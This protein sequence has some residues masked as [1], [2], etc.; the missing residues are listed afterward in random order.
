MPASGTFLR[1]LPF[2]RVWPSLAG[3]RAA[4]VPVR[5]KWR[6]R[7]PSRWVGI[8]GLIG[9]GLVVLET[10]TSWLQ[11]ELLAATAR[12]L[13]YTVEA[14]P[15]AS[16]RF[17]PDGPY[18]HRLGY[19]LQPEFMPRLLQGGFVVQEQAR[20]SPTALTL[21][22]RGVFHIH[23]EKSQAGLV[24]LDRAG[25]PLADAR[26]PR[27]V[28]QRFD[29]IPPLIV[30]TIL[31]IENRSLLR[32]GHP[33]R[34]PAVEYPRLVHAG[35]E[36]GLQLVF[37]R[38]PAS[39][40]S[41]LATQLEKIR[42]S[43]GGRTRSFAD[44]GT[45]MLSAS[46]RAYLDGVETT[47]ARER[48]VLDYLNSLPLGA[49]AGHGEVFGLG[50]GLWAWYDADFDEVNASLASGGLVPATFP[51]VSDLA[52]AYRQVLSLLLAIKKP[53][54]YLVS[55][56]AS[57]DARIDGY[58][59]A[60][61]QAEVISPALR[62]EA[63]GVRVAPRRQVPLP[64]VPFAERKATDRVRTEL[65]STLGLSS[66]YD[67]DRLD[68]TVHSTLD[69]EATSAVTAS[70]QQLSD[71]SYA[72]N[73]GV[74]AERLLGTGD[75][76]KVLYSF[77]LYERG[78]TGH[79]L[80]VQADNYDGPLNLNEGTRLELGSTAKLRTLVS[81]LQVIEALHGRYAGLPAEALN[82]VRPH[83]RD[84]LTRWAV[85][86][87]SRTTS[88]GLD[89]MLE[90][91]MVRRYSASP[92]ETFFTGGGLHRFG[93][94]DGK[95]DGRVLT[96]REAFER[97]VNLV[98]VRLMRDVVDHHV[99]RSPELGR[100]LEDRTHPARRGYLE[101]FADQE[102]REFLRRFHARNVNASS[103]DLLKRFAAAGRASSTRLAMIFRSVRPDAGPEDLSAFLEFHGL[104]DLSQDRV[105]DL[106]E[107]YDPARWNLQDRGYIAGVHPLELWL[108]GYLDQ[109]PAAGLAEV[110]DAS[111]AARQEAYLWLFR[112][113]NTRAQD[114]SIR[115]LLEQDAFSA[116]HAS[117]QRLGYPFASL[118]PSYAT[119]LG[120]SGDNPAALAD[121]VGT[122]LNGGV[123]QPA[124][125]IDELLFGEGTP[126]HTRL[127]RPASAGERVLSPE[128]AGVLREALVGV[129]D[130]GTGRRLAGGV[131]LDGGHR[132]VVG[133]KTGTGDNRFETVGPSGRTQRV[134]NR[135]AAFVFT[136]GERHFGTIVAFVPGSD[137]ARY[138]FTSALPVQIF[139]HLVPALAPLLE[140]EEAR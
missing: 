90:A 9:T 82:A 76:H 79:R 110:M 75:L 41:T 94:F 68:L 69:G 4:S 114:R 46:L 54:A 56:P 108:A 99:F 97:S 87:L 24:V 48:L 139:R 121:L 21:A 129:V 71:R 119:A 126:Y 101:R 103:A 49:I 78:P 116:I 3:R 63:R 138:S 132:L 134:V 80:L 19:A 18:N 6:F 60:L 64:P 7:R 35:L 70:L 106:H 39:G 8:A 111:E 136:V 85:E 13:T 50:D 113:R 2:D 36:A 74:L 100:V 84:R 86:Y 15:A 73:A 128:V 28:Y 43:P 67:L 47:A 61:A 38:R 118:V 91:A 65:L 117:W 107:Q 104:R 83:A 127:A 42:H 140:Q 109:H 125:R 17:P 92:A 72:R 22:D 25:R 93:N 122:I 105:R 59:G 115:T 31:F 133:G 58:L 123:R 77:T 1:A 98:F 62:D 135:T 96:V 120:S 124:V 88:R 30:Q 20:W 11:S 34:N 40:G 14:G 57:L 12:R 29:D 66:V 53:T 45:Q 5:P 137:A 32:D 81:Y 112:T 95:D 130:E 131:E 27:R 10:R 52:L 23:H 44:K 51:N 26:D 55:D 33:R 16:V 37:P 89:A 102:G